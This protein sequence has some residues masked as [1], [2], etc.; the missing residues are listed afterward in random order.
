MLKGVFIPKSLNNTLASWSLIKFYFYDHTLHILIKALF[1][2]FLSLQILDF[3]FLYFF[4]TSNN[5][6]TLVNRW[7][8]I[9]NNLFKSFNFLIYSFKLS[10]SF[11]TLFIK[12]NSAWLIFESIKALEIK[13]SMLF[14]ID[15]ANNSIS[16]SLFFFFLIINLWFLISA[17]IAQICDP[18]AKLVIP[19]RIPSKEVKPK[20][21]VHPVI[22]E[23]NRR[24]FS[25]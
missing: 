18:I 10:Y 11:G 23:V 13:P 17:V 24:K 14:N 3:Y 20:I 25:I 2:R 7:I 1:F 9:F 16:S 15:F 12:I 6:I 21:Q 8:K 4:H 5:T 22:V 19:I